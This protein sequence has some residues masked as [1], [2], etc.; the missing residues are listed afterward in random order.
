MSLTHTSERIA[1]RIDAILR[2]YPHDPQFHDI[3]SAFAQLFRLTDDLLPTS[4][5]K[6]LMQR[7]LLE[8]AHLFTDA[9][10]MNT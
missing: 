3:R 10:E 9:V 8:A 2:E 7:K 5:E 4:G 1:G 6:T